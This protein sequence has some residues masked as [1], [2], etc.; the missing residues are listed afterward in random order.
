VL[1]V[2]LARSRGVSQFA[3]IHDSYGT[4]AADTGA[5]WLATRQA[6]VE[7]YEEHDVL[8]ELR[9]T[10]QRVLGDG[11]K[12]PECP[13]KGKLDLSALLRCEDGF[14][15][16]VFVD[17]NGEMLLL[18]R[19]KNGFVLRLPDQKPGRASYFFN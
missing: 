12:V 7:M 5:L 1:T 18:D 17:E 6:F 10:A 19:D 13:E 15:I 11:E 9:E 2:N 14:L 8:E 3:M 4:A 16:D